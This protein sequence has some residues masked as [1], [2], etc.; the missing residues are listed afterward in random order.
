MGEM[1]VLLITPS[2]GSAPSRAH[3]QILLQ[4]LGEQDERCELVLVTRGECAIPVSGVPDNVIL[5]ALSAPRSTSLSAARNLAMT[6]ARAEGL[7]R[8]CRGV[9]FP[10]DDC[11]YPPGALRRAVNHM[12][13]G[14]DMVCAVYGPAPGAVDWKRF[15]SRPQEVDI[16]LIMRSQSS[17]TM[18]FTGDLV[19][20]LGDFDERLGLGARFGSAEDCDYM[21]RALVAGARAVYDPGL[22]V[23]HPYKRLRHEQYFA[24]SAAVLAKHAFGRGRTLSALFRRLAVGLVLLGRRQLHTSTYVAALAAAVQM[25]P[26]AGRLTDSSASRR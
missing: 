23:L 18:F 2:D 22:L 21:I 1:S 10:D 9:A 16:R 24:G 19:T 26:V 25:L 7:L 11:V 8:A 14:A 4:S 5:H 20:A 13:L 12:R 15:P 17:G 6:Q 3:I